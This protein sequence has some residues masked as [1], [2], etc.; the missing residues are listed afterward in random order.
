M[1]HSIQVRTTKLRVHV[2]AIYGSS[3][4]VIE[5]HCFH[6]SV[7]LLRLAHISDVNCPL[8]K[9]LPHRIAAALLISFPVRRR[10]I[11]ESFHVF[12]FDSQHFFNGKLKEGLSPPNS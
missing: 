1:L 12:V 7:A 10:H 11:S 2:Y 4:L 5:D 8:W 3:D 6:N 9:I